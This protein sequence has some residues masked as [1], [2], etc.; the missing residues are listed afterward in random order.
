MVMVGS[1]ENPAGYIG[2]PQVN[3]IMKL[4]RIMAMA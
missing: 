1:N 3:E 2:T 4:V